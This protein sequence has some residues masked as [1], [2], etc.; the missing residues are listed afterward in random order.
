MKTI[1]LNLDIELLSEQEMI[2][3]EGGGHMY[4]LGYSF[5]KATIVCATVA[6]L[7][8]FMALS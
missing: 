1:E 5:G 8:A 7:A 3:I 6:G 2:D 4:S